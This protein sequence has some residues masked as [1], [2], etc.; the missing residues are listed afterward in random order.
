MGRQTFSSH[1]P[2]CPW[3]DHEHD[4]DGDFFYDEALTKYE[5]EA[6][7]KPFNMRAYTSTTWTCTIPEEAHD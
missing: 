1:S 4:H 2:I 5:C 7:D 6:C 3:C